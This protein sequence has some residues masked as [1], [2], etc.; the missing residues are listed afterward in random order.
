MP[1]YKLIIGIVASAIGLIGY[2]PYSLDMIKG[3]TKPHVFSWLVW[4]LLEG[5]AFFAQMSEGAGAGAL[6]T[7]TSAFFC[8]VIALAALFKGEKN[9]TRFDWLAFSG[10][11][12]GLVLWRLT[13]SPLSAVIL[14]TITDLLVFAPTFRKSYYKPGEETAISYIIASIRLAMSLLAMSAF[15]LTTALYPASLVLSNTIFVIMLY[16]RRKQLKINN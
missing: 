16:V 8:S 7:G 15:N 10:A 9:I 12:I 13:S 2:I 14:I 3:K 5:I 1:D 6:V 4:G 11:L